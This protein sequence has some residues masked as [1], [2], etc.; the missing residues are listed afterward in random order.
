[1]VNG[2]LMLATVI[3][4]VNRHWKVS[5]FSHLKTKLSISSDICWVVWEEIKNGLLSGKIKS[6]FIEC[7]L[8]RFILLLFE[9]SATTHRLSTERVSKLFT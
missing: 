4:P 8:Y 6:I 7:D 2:Q 9:D 3:M 5:C 1:M